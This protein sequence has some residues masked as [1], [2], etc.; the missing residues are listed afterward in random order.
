M[1]FVLTLGFNN[2]GEGFQTIGDGSEDFFSNGLTPL[3]APEPER[4][5][6]VQQLKYLNI[7]D[8]PQTIVIDNYDGNIHLQTLNNNYF[9]FTK[10]ASDVNE[11]KFYYG[12]MGEWFTKNYKLATIPTVTHSSNDYELTFANFTIYHGIQY[13]AMSFKKQNEE[14]YKSVTYKYLN[15]NGILEPQLYHTSE[16]FSSRSFIT[17]KIP[18]SPNWDYFLHRESAKQ[19]IRHSQTQ[20]EI[21]VDE[22][23][24]ISEDEKWLIS[25]RNDN[26]CY[27]V[28]LETKQ[29]TL[30]GLK[31]GAHEKDGCSSYKF[32]NNEI[33][34]QNYFRSNLTNSNYEEKDIKIIDFK[35]SK[36]FTVPPGY[37]NYDEKTT[38]L[39]FLGSDNKIKKQYLSDFLEAKNP[40]VSYK[41]ITK[42]G[43]G[44]DKAYLVPYFDQFVS[45][46]YSEL[47]QSNFF[48]NSST[49]ASI[50]LNELRPK[51]ENA[52]GVNPRT[53]YANISKYGDKL[54]MT[55]DS[56]NYYL[57]QLE[58]TPS[59][60]EELPEY[61]C[62]ISQE[63]KNKLSETCLWDLV[64]NPKQYKN[65]FKFNVRYPLSSESL[66]SKNRWVYIPPGTK[67]DNSDDNNW[68]YPQGT[69][70]FKNFAY[71][72]NKENVTT[73]TNI[74]T[75]ILE[76]TTSAIG[77]DAWRPSVYVW[78]DDQTDAVYTT[79]GADIPLKYN[80]YDYTYKVPSLASCTQCHRGNNDMAAGFN[81]L[82]LDSGLGVHS[83][84]HSYFDK[85][86]LSKRPTIYNDI[87]NLDP[88]KVSGFSDSPEQKAI[89]YLSTNCSG[90]HSPK[91][92]AS[93]IGL[94]FTYKLGTTDHKLTN[95]YLTATEKGYVIPGDHANSKVYTAVESGYMPKGSVLKDTKLTAIIRNWID[96]LPKEE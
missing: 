19:Y 47:S 87:P 27:A 24:S 14:F 45:T 60:I 36:T 5:P 91:G 52:L 31:T 71:S 89:G 70:F 80:S 76:K 28:N 86:L 78:S 10:S 26:N 9:S 84:L 33:I 95:A 53:Y 90:C 22:L 58:N 57:V 42:E 2:C 16:E 93:F 48:I 92:V 96:A 69:I 13:L 18:L 88:T 94:D 59:Q 85:G 3:P 66:N 35:N 21:T 23:V 81:Q 83:D 38:A 15:N 62:T 67:I 8:Q 29:F 51:P 54:Y 44:M 50:N 43:F 17:Q 77:A 37:F 7:S 4:P 72:E 32:I 75:R 40:T 74:E 65:F 82:Q 79:D 11:L 46:Y 63:P 73:Y 68:V 56:K 49:G 30:L 64:N 61:N 6:L 39:T 41:T 12:T 1:I 20:E 55:Y 34:R 25:D